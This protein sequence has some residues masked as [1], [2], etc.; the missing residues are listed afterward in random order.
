MDEDYQVTW[1]E[2]G[3][4]LRIFNHKLRSNESSAGLTKTTKHLVDQTLLPPQ[5]DVFL[6]HSNHHHNQK[7]GG[8][9]AKT[10]ML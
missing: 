8:I 2:Y 7:G 4:V 9:A 1:N 3:D 10:P 6:C 5:D